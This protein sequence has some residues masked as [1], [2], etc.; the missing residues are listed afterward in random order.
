MIRMER[1]RPAV[2]VVDDQRGQPTWTVDVAG[3]IMALGQCPTASGVYHATS[4]GETTWYG[5]AREVFRL[6]GADPARVRPTTSS[7]YS[8]RAPRPA[9][10]VLGHEAWRSAGIAEIGDWKQP[11]CTAFPALLAAET[12]AATS[13]GME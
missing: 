10:S 1:A 4:S 5:L 12:V 3:Q 6:L 13:Y 8:R 11:L 9:Y 7:T 2:D